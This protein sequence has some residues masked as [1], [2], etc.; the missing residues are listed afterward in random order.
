MSPLPFDQSGFFGSPVWP[1]F[2]MPEIHRPFLSWSFGVL[3]PSCRY[4]TSLVAGR[5][6]SGRALA[7]STR[8]TTS[9]HD[10]DRYGRDRA[11]H[12]LLRVGRRRVGNMSSDHGTR[13]IST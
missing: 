4:C 2:T 8:A 7:A 3:T 9:T 12:Q 11:H 10:A 5:Q 1:L 13:K 6:L